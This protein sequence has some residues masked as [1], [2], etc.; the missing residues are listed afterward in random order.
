MKEGILK[1][2]GLRDGAGRA[3]EIREIPVD[4]IEVNPYQPR[5]GLD[6]DDLEELAASIREHGVIQPILVRPAGSKFELVAGERR[7][8]ASRLAGL[9]KVPAIVR[10]MGDH[11]AALLALVENLQREDLNPLEEAEAYQRI[12][13]MFK[14][15]QEELARKVG[16]SQSAVANKIRLLRLPEEARM[17]ISREIIT[18]RHARCLL[19]LDDVEEQRRVVEEIQSKEL[20]VRET[21]ELVLSILEGRGDDGLAH[22]PGEG[23]RG[24][25]VLGAIKDLRIF[26][27]S[28]RQAVRALKSSGIEAEI[29]EQDKGEYIEISV[30]VKKRRG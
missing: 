11:E 30:R 2:L 22:L 28:F 15:T 27:N 24:R 8:R 12:L 21:E 25:R 7:W 3:G 23:R 5:R 9:K 19:R 14:V 29:E 26:L 17:A 4:S 20:T 18:E 13:D 1:A 10:V 6:P 16:R